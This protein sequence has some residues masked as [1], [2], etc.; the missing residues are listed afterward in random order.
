[1]AKMHIKEGDMVYVLNGKDVGKKGKVLSVI[2]SK[3]KIVVEGVN[4]VTKHVKPKPNQGFT[5]GGLVHQEAPIFV[6]KVMLI[7]KNCGKP[8]KIGRKFLDNGSKARY[9]KKCEEVIDI[10]GKDKE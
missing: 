7:C 4:V 3:R 9:C 1:M 6:D 5:E 8:A 10:I 2:P